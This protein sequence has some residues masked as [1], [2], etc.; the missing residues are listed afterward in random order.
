[1]KPLD[2]NELFGKSGHTEQTILF[3]QDRIKGHIVTVYNNLFSDCFCVF[4]RVTSIVYFFYSSFV[5]G[6]VGWIQ[7]L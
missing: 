2:P 6:S 4:L 1:M 7:S 3:I 5:I